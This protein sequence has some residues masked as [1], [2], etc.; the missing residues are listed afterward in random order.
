[1]PTSGGRG[2]GEGFNLNLPLE[3]GA[4]I[5][6][7]L[8]ALETALQRIAD[9]APTRLVLA[10]GLDIAIDDPFKAFAIRTEDFAQIGAR[11]AQMRLPTLVVQEG[12]YPSR[13][14]V[15]TWR[16]F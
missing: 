8:A 4:D 12:G 3:R 9:F 15:T 2:A 11:I 6:I 5:E 13:H 16:R 1:M 14:W 10:S 7:Y